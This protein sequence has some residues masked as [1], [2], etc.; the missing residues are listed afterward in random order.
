MTEIEKIK[1]GF[2]LKPKITLEQ[3]IDERNNKMLVYAIAEGNILTDI[4]HVSNL[5][6]ECFTN[7]VILSVLLIAATQKQLEMMNSRY[8]CIH[9]K[10][11]ERLT[12]LIKEAAEP[13][14][15]SP[16]ISE[17]KLIKAVV[18]RDN[19][20][21]IR[22]IQEEN[23]KFYGFAFELLLLLPELSKA[24]ILTFLQEGLSEKLKAIIFGIFLKEAATP[25]LLNDFSYKE[26]IKYA[27]LMMKIIAGDD[28]DFNE[29]WYPECRE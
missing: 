11:G 29:E 1:T 23:A 27:N 6:Y 21:I 5:D 14:P 18:F 3:A 4:A 26:R 25:E 28:I 8:F 2:D 7:E 9:S 22:L 24:A 19:A 10:V 15:Q 13:L 16:S 17:K 12:A 20:E